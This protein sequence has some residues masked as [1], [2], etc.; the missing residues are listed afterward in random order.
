MVFNKEVLS[1]FNAAR[2]FEWLETN[3]IGGYAS[4]TVSGAHSRRYHGLLITA[5][6]PPVGR[7]NMISKIDETIIR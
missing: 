1:D 3:G 6:K 5:T 2:S 4:G 7:M